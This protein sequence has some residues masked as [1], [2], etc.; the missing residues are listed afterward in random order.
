MT[1]GPATALGEQVFPLSHAQRRL[2]FLDRL[3][4]RSP[5]YNI[6]V[7]SRV[8]EH[9][10]AGAL[11]AAVTDVVGRHEILR[12]IYLE[13]G[14]EP[15]QRVLPAGAARIDFAH[16]A[17]PADQ[18]D[19]RLAAA[20]ARTFDLSADLPLSVR[21]LTVGPRDHVLVVVLHHIA[22]DGVSMGP[23]SRDLTTAYAARLAGTSP[24]WP[25]L[26]VQYS[27]Y[28]LWQREL[29]GGG[30]EPTS[31]M[32]RQLAFWRR[33][34]A[35]LPEELVLPTDFPRPA[36]ASYRGGT[37][38]F[39]TGAALHARL[40][41]FAHTEN[42]TP[43][44]VVH[45]AVAALLTRLG[46]G[47]DVPLGTAVA[48]RVDEALD[49]LVGLFVN[50]LVLRADTGGDPTF[51]ELVHRVRDVDLAAFEHQDVPFERLVEALRPS[52]SLARHPLF[53]VFFILASGGAGDVEMLGLPSTT[54]RTAGDTAKFDLSFYLSEERDDAGRPAGIKGVVEYSADLFG[55][56]AAEAIA[57]ALVRLLDAVLT[58]PGTRL[59][60]ID[61][62]D[63][64]SRHRLLVTRNDTARP[65]PAV[66]CTDLV[67]E[68]VARTPER[69]AVVAGGT[70]LTYRELDE[71]A[72]RLAAELRARGVGPE[73]FVA[74]AMDRTVT[75]VVAVLAVWKAGGAYLPV[76]TTYP[77][78]RIAFMLD[79]GGPALVL[80][81]P[82]SA[83]RVPGDRDRLVLDDAVV[84]DLPAAGA[85]APA[86]TP[87]NAAYVIY[88]SGSTGRPKGVVVSHANLVNFQ[89][90]M[91]RRLRLG[92]DDRF[93]A[94]T[95][96]AFDA[97]VL[98]LYPPLISGGVLVLV[99]RA[100]VREPAELG[101]LIER[102]RVTVMQ[103]TPSLWQMLVTA[104]PEAV[105][106]VRKLTGGEALPRGLAD[107]LRATGGEVLNLYG[108]TE[109]TVYSTCAPVGARPGA[110]AIGVPVD[111]TRVYVLDDTLAPVPEGTAGELYL[112][113]AGVSRGY[114]RRPGLTAA[115][116]PADPHG[117]PGS[118]MYRTGDLARWARDGHLEYLGRTDDQVKI[119]GFRIE[120][121]E[122][123]AALDAHPGVRRSVVVAR[124]SANGDR[125]LVGYVAAPA[126]PD[127]DG[128]RAHLAA[129]LPGYMV[130]SAF[131]CLPALPLTANGKVDR[132]ALPAPE[133]P[134]GGRPA[135]TPRQ[136]VLCDLFA[137][138]LGVPSPGVD[139]SF[140]DLGG[141]SLLATR[142]VSRIAAVLGADVSVRTVFAA[143]TV[144]RLDRV[145]GTGE[146]DA[147][148]P[149][150]SYRDSGDRTPVFLLPPANGLG[151]A[152]S[153]LPRHLPA[154]HPVH[155]L[156]DPRLAGGPVEVRSVTELAAEY[157]RRIAA[158]RGS[159]PCILAGW[160]FGGTLALQIAADLRARGEEVALLV[161]LDAHPGG[162]GPREIS[163]GHAAFVGLEGLTV[164]DGQS[165]RAALTAAHSPLAS[166]DD[167]TLDR[168][169]AVT[170]AN[171]LA[172][173]RHEP[174]T[175][176][177][178]V[179]GFTA[180][181]DNPGAG[182]WRPFLTGTT[183]FH[184]LDC[185]HLDIVKAAVL[186]TIGPIIGER[187]S[188]VG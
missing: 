81:D 32:S 39:E 102:E 68:Q 150:L 2:W 29:L 160:S 65:L 60:R 6:P 179:L 187:V 57:A 19:A 181:R 92:A 40:T 161:V 131:V 20:C 18:L 27:D 152:Y 172:M 34:L 175:F 165:R 132:A 176:D 24:R 9:V 38:E 8:H 168:L 49:E 15:V 86:G 126:A 88:T 125:S 145:L 4:G 143:P 169:V 72:T 98:E 101:A 178:P 87:D 106:P 54:L 91:R 52:R 56:S 22:S 128:L 135:A 159:G 117:P 25:S 17:V 66:R 137:E 118:R 142:L 107:R 44:M 188:D 174:A 55:R 134:V 37:V 47:T 166:L 177:G 42:V 84:A 75:L 182:A 94:V 156:Q 105:R 129:R 73:T 96:T 133:R 162:D 35:D 77:A 158:V 30:D 31:E 163:P 50:S 123:E 23:L 51:R 114:H 85:L 16:E 141:H 116:F 122:V 74:I 33:T 184:D 140:F 139:D 61:V 151:W 97:S 108:P 124:E 157:G 63:A 127:L 186:S 112:A 10:D 71:R 76:D 46:C 45:A 115:R 154:G 83:D 148:G 43:F 41:A 130:P 149:V 113:G 155:A 90:A 170:G 171:L 26:P 147:P 48:G 95:T 111:N 67:E 82:D 13:A 69:V 104:V 138:V 185:G 103:A 93:A 109:T 136:Q 80:T 180:T 99:P 121:G 146:R 89:L 100:A 78:E 110:P 1:A 70:A 120:L 5:M 59:G 144:A 3:E 11:R 164:P 64:A 7:I 183:D 62:L 21:L 36:E 58:D 28:V 79:D 173:A 14:G 167:G 12:T 119:R 53:Q 153:A